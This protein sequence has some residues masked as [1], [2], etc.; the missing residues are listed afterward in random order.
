M[1]IDK[2]VSS[3]YNTRPKSV[4]EDMLVGN[5]FRENPPPVPPPPLNYSAYTTQVSGMTCTNILITYL[6]EHVMNII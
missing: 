1:Q 2:T 6:T 4:C 5:F 3:K